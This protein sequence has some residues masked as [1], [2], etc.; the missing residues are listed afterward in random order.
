[1]GMGLFLVVI[2]MMTVLVL[3]TFITYNS[4]RQGLT[5]LL[6]I[7]FMVSLSIYDNTI[8]K[9]LPKYKINDKVQL[10]DNTWGNIDSV[11]YKIEGVWYNQKVLKD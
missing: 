2:I 9:V 8:K 5:I 11:A 3:L 10:P 7:I 4:L 1:M 6:L